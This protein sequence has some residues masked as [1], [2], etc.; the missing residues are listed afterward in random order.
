MLYDNELK[1]VTKRDG[2]VVPFDR[3]E[4]FHQL[5][6]VFKVVDGQVTKDDMQLINQVTDFVEYVLNDGVSTFEIQIEVENTLMDTHRKDVAK[7][8]IIR[9]YQKENQRGQ[10]DGVAH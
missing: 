8:F 2:S 6:D 9:G 10:K 7:L 4:I 1:T 5:E 3:M